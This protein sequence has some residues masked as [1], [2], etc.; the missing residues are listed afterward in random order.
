M[1]IGDT[2]QRL[3]AWAS[4]S[5]SHCEACGFLKES[6]VLFSLH[7]QAIPSKK[8][9]VKPPPVDVLMNFGF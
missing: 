2:T 5:Y 4:A 3:K 8:G 1:R 6:T 9:V 7:Q